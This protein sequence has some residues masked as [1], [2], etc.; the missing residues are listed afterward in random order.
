MRHAAEADARGALEA[1]IS[2]AKDENAGTA[3]GQAAGESLAEIMIRRGQLGSKEYDSLPFSQ[4]TAAADEAYDQAV[5]RF[6]R[7]PRAG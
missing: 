1:L 2:V 3:V 7:S 5:A 4:F 6:L